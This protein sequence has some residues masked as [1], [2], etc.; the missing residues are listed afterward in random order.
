[1]NTRYP[2]KT[3][4]P[5]LAAAVLFTL[6]LLAEGT[7]I[8]SASA[9]TAAEIV[10]SVSNLTGN[11]TYTIEHSSN[12]VSNDWNEVHSFEGVPGTTNWTTTTTEAGFFRAIQDPYHPKVGKVAT[13]STVAH[14]VQGTAHIVNNRTVEL[15]NFYFDGGGLDVQVYVS[16]NGT[17]Y[18]PY[19][20]L[21]TNL[22]G[23]AYE[24]ETVVLAIPEGADLD[25]FQYISIWCV[26]VNFSFGDGY[27]Q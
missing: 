10:I 13:F 19:I 8:L 3:G 25:D 14:N 1:M 5:Y 2:H 21:S 9:T 22:V 27:F 20:S 18:D 6:P 23:T 7:P 11:A 4:L 26:D 17:S 15:R 24:D 12:L 16:T